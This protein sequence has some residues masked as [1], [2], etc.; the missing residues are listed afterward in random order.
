MGNETWGKKEREKKKQ[1]K[2]MDKIEKKLD[3]K[4]NNNKGKGLD[5]MMAYLDDNGNLTSIKP[6]PKTRRQIDI[7]D[8][9][10]SIPK[11]E[12]REIQSIRT[13]VVKFFDESK[14]YGFIDDALSKESVFVHINALSETI[15]EGDKVT[16]ETE[17]NARG[18]AAVNVKK[19]V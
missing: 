16:F 4:D 15:K 17:Q 19:I 2:K 12:D 9:Q 1:K 13:G 6:D 8:I 7:A 10:I 11:Q 14:G 18:L 3:K 5:D